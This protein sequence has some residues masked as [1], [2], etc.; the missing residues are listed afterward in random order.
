MWN[1]VKLV[2]WRWFKKV[3]DVGHEWKRWSRKWSLCRGVKS[4]GYRDMR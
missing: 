2:K 1:S 4:L 3:E